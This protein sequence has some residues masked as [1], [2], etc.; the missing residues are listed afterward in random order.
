MWLPVC[1]N[2]AIADQLRGGDME[3]DFDQ[4]F[5]KKASSADSAFLWHQVGMQQMTSQQDEGAHVYQLRMP[6]NN[7]HQ[8]V[9]IF[10]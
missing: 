5:S 7:T 10:A 6:G 4:I 9:I 2:Q 1:S 3:I 8:L